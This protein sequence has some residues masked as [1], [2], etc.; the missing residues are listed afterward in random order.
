MAESQT[1]RSIRSYVKRESRM[2][3]A[4]HRALVTLW[5]NYGCDLAALDSPCAL[6]A[7]DAPCYLEIGFGNGE[8]LAALAA[9]HPNCDFFGV[10]V[11]RPG[12][13]QC[14]RMLEDSHATNVRV[15]NADILQVVQQAVWNQK[16]DGIYLLFPDPWPKRRHHKRRLVSTPFIERLN[17]CLKPG[18]YLYIATDWEPYAA[19]CTELFQS[20]NLLHP[21]KDPERLPNFIARTPTRYEKRG[22]GLGH[23]IQELIYQRPL[24]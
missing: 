19:H 17:T 16:L 6:F 14:L 12:V 7:R 24:T 8:N 15:I 10:E 23:P 18:G 1:R 11:H 4:Q 21:V 22:L 13:G 3:Q 20:Q 5:P 2:S 9:L